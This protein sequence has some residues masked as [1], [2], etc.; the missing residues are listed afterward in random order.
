MISIESQYITREEKLFIRR[1]IVYTLD[2]L[3]PRKNRKN[4][5]LSVRIEPKGTSQFLHKSIKSDS[6]SVTFRESSTNCKIWIWNK[7][8]N[9]NGKT[10]Y[11]KFKNM[12]S[13]LFHELVHVKQFLRGE[14]LDI[15]ETHYRYKGKVYKLGDEFHN[16]MDYY[17]RPEEIEAYGLE[18]GLRERFKEFWKEEYER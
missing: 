4:Y 8:I 15:N 17:K 13:Y 3:I 14:L 9:K 18:V 6:R 10:L 11:S 7:L 16:I 1:A 2:Y 5:Q 12:L